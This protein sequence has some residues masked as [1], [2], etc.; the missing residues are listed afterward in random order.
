MKKY[1]LYH[2][3]DDCCDIEGLFL[4]AEQAPTCN[5][6]ENVIEVS[7]SGFT[8]EGILLVAGKKIKASGQPTGDNTEYEFLFSNFKLTQAIS[9]GTK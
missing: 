9:E 8:K 2:I 5:Y 4:E 6:D 7:N 1:F 3:Y